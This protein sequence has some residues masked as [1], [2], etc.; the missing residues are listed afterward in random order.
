[1]T[2]LFILA[3]I[4]GV[5]YC[6]W[7][8]HNKDFNPTVHKNNKPQTDKPQKTA[9]ITQHE[10]QKKALIVKP[11]GKREIVYKDFDWP[12]FNEWHG[13]FNAVGYWPAMW[14]TIAEYTYLQEYPIEE[15]LPELKKEKLLALSAQYGSKANK[16]LKKT[17]IIESLVAIIPAS[18]TAKILELV[19]ELWRPRFI[20]AKQEL[21]GHTVAF[22]ISSSDNI[23]IWQ[24]WGQKLIEIPAPVDDCPF[25]KEKANRKIKLSAMTDADLPPFHPGC[26]CTILPVD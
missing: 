26:R 18:D 17:E 14:A 8:G 15:L 21:Q 20:K 1:M 19:N 3:A 12:E 5:F 25:C 22:R 16:N 10:A 2:I 9:I 11:K 6:M 24:S 7:R 13:K 23:K 4:C